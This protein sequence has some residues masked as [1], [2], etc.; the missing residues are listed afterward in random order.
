MKLDDRLTAYFR[1]SPLPAG[2]AERVRRAA[3]AAHRDLADLLERLAVE[4]GPEGVRL[5]RPGR[6]GRPATAGARRLVERARE[7]LAEYLAGQ[8]AF[9]SVPVDLSA[10]PAFQRAVLDAA[11]RIP[12]GEAR[13]YAWIARR[14]GQ[15]RAVRAV[16][17]ALGKNPVPLI[18]PCHRVLRTDGS[19]GGYIFGTEVKRRLLDL[20]RR[21][22]VLEGCTSTRIV[23]RVGCRHG[24]HMR[25]DRRVVFASVDD[26]RT[27]GYRPC[28][29][30][31]PA[32]A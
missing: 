9:F 8:R 30:C 16:G 10:A 27:I 20:E 26:A 25:A 4:A 19:A 12:F 32:A 24:R 3:H 23:C 29:V 13:P 11:R 31:K 14:I 17:T 1:P 15:P 18:L 5:I 7:E 2:F 28:K 6:Q 22:P 21:T